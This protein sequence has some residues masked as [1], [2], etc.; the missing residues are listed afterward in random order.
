MFRGVNVLRN[1]DSYGSGIYWTDLNFTWN[2]TDTDHLTVGSWIGFGTQNNAYKELDIYT[3]YTHNFGALDASI[4]YTFYY[5]FSQP[6][7]Y[8]HEL[9]AKLAYNFDFGFMKLVPSLTYYFNIGPDS[10]D[11][12][13]I[14][15]EA[16]SYLLARVDGNIPVI[17][18]VLAVAPWVALGTN[19]EY[20]AKVDGDG[21]LNFFNGVNNLEMGLGFPIKINNVISLYGYGAY[22]YAFYNL[23]GTEP[24]S[25]W[26]GAKVTF[27]F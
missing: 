13:G 21:N 2:I 11:D 1:G 15:P 16:S 18:D 3:S 9:N 17:K 5:V 23:P 19:F 6:E 22:S 8:S 7:L 27:S 25:F 12:A 20:N 10:I 4:G 14:A 24:S 26:A